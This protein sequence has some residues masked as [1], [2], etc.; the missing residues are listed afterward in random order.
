M[1]IDQLNDYFLEN[2]IIRIN[3]RKYKILKLL[4]PL[5]TS[6]CSLAMGIMYK[7]YKLGIV[8]LNYTEILGHKIGKIIKTIKKKLENKRK[9]D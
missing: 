9:N 8:Y 2:K 6:Q 1:T 7:R 4:N 5:F 3:N